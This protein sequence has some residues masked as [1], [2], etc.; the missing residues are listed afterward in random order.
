[1]GFK[2]DHD[3]ETRKSESI[4][5]MNKYPCRIPIIVEKSNTCNLQAIVKKKYLVPK[6]LTMNQF[7]YVIRKRIKLN[8]SE[9]IFLMIDNR[10]CASNTSLDTIYEEY[11]DE[12]GFLYIIYT[13]ENT[14]G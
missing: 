11:A 9:S 14:F 10:L 13:S 1:M 3:F 7:I 2:A 8:S 5:I 4:K 6:D 12:D